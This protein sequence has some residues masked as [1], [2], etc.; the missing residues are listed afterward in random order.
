M[1][2]ALDILLAVEQEAEER[3]QEVLDA[4]AGNRLD[5]VALELLGT[6]IR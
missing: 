6:E 4:F 5:N 3:A 1:G 2:Y